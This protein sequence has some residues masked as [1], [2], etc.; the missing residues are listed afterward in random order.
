MALAE[1][2][3]WSRDP[4]VRDEFLTG[5]MAGVEQAVDGRLDRVASPEELQAAAHEAWVESRMAIGASIAEKE[6]GA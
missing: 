4:N 2:E 3:R 5:F 1:F 6:R